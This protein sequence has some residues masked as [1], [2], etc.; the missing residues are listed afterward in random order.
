MVTLKKYFDTK[1]ISEAGCALDVEL[2]YSERQKNKS[3][4]ISFCPGRKN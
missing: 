3:S 2:K 4:Q 1:D